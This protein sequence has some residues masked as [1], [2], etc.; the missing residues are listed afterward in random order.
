[1]VCA[2]GPLAGTT[3]STVKYTKR[4]NTFKLLTQDGAKY[5]FSAHTEQQM[6][7][8]V[9]KI[10]FHAALPP[11]MLLQHYAPFSMFLIQNIQNG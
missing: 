9:K 3:Y 11:S 1:M 10:S 8:W 2:G 6:D 7:D 5:L 4:K